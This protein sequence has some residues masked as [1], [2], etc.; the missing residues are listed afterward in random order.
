M[1]AGENCL[2]SSVPSHL[3]LFSFIVIA[4]CTAIVNQLLNFCHFV[5]NWYFCSI[6]NKIMTSTEGAEGGNGNSDLPF[7]YLKMVCGQYLSWEMGFVSPLLVGA[8]LD[9]LL[10]TSH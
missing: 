7:F 3:R 2:L 6:V 4:L 9:S 1:I 8:R 5:K 10:I